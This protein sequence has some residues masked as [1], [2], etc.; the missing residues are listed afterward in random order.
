VLRTAAARN[1]LNNDDDLG[2]SIGERSLCF[3]RDNHCDSFFV[4]KLVVSRKCTVEH[5]TEVDPRQ[6][7]VT[8]LNDRA[9][10]VLERPIHLSD[11]PSEKI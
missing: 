11:C 4:V 9:P 7:V 8:Q 2:A 6:D 3:D 1:P 10:P 5:M